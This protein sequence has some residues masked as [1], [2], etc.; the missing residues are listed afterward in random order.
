MPSLEL[1]GIGRSYVQ[2]GQAVVALQDVNLRIDA[3]EMVA[4]VG[5]SGSGKSTLLNILGCLDRPSRGRY[6]IDGRDV[7]TLRSDELAA[8]RQRCFGFVF[9]RYQLL[10]Q[11]DALDNV[12]LPAVYAGVGAARRRERAAALLQ[13]LGLRD[14]ASHRPTALSGGQQQRVSIARALMN[15]GAVILAD[16]PTGALDSHSGA[17]L[18][19]LLQELH[20]RGHTVL[21]ITHDAAVASHARRIIE[22]C[23]GRIVR[24]TARGATGTDAVPDAEPDAEPDAAPGAALPAPGAAPAPI[25]SEPAARRGR[26]A[27]QMVQLRE[28]LAMAVAALRG[29]RLRSA[30]SMFG[31]SIGIAAVV[32]IVTLTGAA[33]ARV[34]GQLHSLM[35]GR[36]IV[37]R[38]TPDL[39][40]GDEG[41]AFRDAELD[42]LRV[43]PGVASVDAARQM[44][45]AARHGARNA[46]LE[47]NGADT[48]ALRDH[49]LRI[50]LGRGIN[51]HD[52][53]ARAQVAVLDRRARD[54][55]FGPTQSALGATVMLE[56]QPFVVI[57][58]ADP[59][60]GPI[61]T[62]GWKGQIFIPDTTFQA[63]LDPS[64]ALAYF[65]LRVTP[66][67][68][69][70]TV[71]KQT[72]HRLRALHG[73]E[74][75]QIFSL[76]DEYRQFSRTTGLLALLLTAVAAIA[77]LVGGVGV[78]NIMLVAVAERTREIGIR[79]ALG[80]R[81]SDI[82]RQFLLES[83]VLCCGGGAAGL[84]LSWI[85]AQAFNQLQTGFPLHLAWPALLLAFGVSCVT[86]LVAGTLPAR[87]AAALSPVEALARE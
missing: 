24:D 3:G 1:I 61:G 71:E 29:N 27:R 17:E 2:A 49:S 45:V 50:S 5:A 37:V 83:V 80:A 82:Q 18:L 34:E 78:M 55:L 44:D 26:W 39:P 74:D 59:V 69:P 54:A 41:R 21:I 43:L 23:D 8:L 53:E 40:P 87:R 68:D 9:Q 15:G 16:E 63:K 4:I 56:S 36:M 46:A 66:G 84:A 64:P 6:L 77:L 76:E 25:Q 73:S 75:F 10:A 13:R 47:L 32:S 35:A 52:L 48:A 7:A 51:G 62:G 86:G 14:R 31:I 30:L 65:S 19:R 28:A 33:Q 79:K 85:A 67:T 38:G 60:A 57:G 70:A 22:L 42:T 20:R 12:A 58:I 72:R 81:E 11:L